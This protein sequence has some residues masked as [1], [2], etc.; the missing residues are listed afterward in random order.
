VRRWLLPALPLVVLAALAGLFAFY[1]LKKADT[2]IEPDFT[3]GKPAPDMMLPYLEG[4]PPVSV[5][6]E[7]KGPALVNIFASWCIPCAVEAPWLEKLHDQGVRIVGLDQGQK[8][9]RDPLEDINAF[10]ARYGDPYAVIFNDEKAQ[11]V[12]DYGATGVPETFVVDSRGMIVDKKTG[13]I[14]TQA[15]MDKLLASLRAAR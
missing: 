12:I 2:R 7:I 15:D 4:G 13:P 6:S 14:E 9:A 1:A 11:A 3:V 5:L 8:G 10:L